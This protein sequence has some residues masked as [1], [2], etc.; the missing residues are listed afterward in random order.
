MERDNM[1]A[2]IK[3]KEKAPLLIN[4][5]NGTVV[6]TDD[7]AFEVININDKEKVCTLKGAYMGAD[8]NNVPIKILEFIEK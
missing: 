4:D 8:I 7:G 5:R 1:K 2:R 3:D 6:Y